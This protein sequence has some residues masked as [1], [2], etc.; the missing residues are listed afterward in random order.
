M[1]STGIAYRNNRYIITTIRLRSVRWITSFCGE[2][3]INGQYIDYSECQARPTISSDITFKRFALATKIF[4][5]WGSSI[6]LV[7][8]SEENYEYSGTR[9]IGYSGALIPTYDQGYGGINKVYWAN[10]FEFLNHFS[11][12][13]TTSYL[14]GS[15]TNKNIILGSNI[16]FEKQQYF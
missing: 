6:G 2:I 15:I 12:G 4:N 7:P 10:G 5:H 11:I 14:F 13:I 3:G 8:Y 16:S 1:A 9:P